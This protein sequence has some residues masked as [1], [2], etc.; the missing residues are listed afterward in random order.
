MLGIRHH[1]RVLEIGSGNRPRS[2]STVLCDR[3]L[4]D[5]V[6]RGVGKTLVLDSRPFVVADGQSLPF[7]DK[8]FD[9]VIVSH[10][11]EHV[12]DPHRF[13]GELMRVALAGYIETPS[14]LGEKIFGWAFH[15]WIVRVDGQRLVLRPRL[16]DSPFGTY[17]HDLYARDLVF[18]EFVDSHYSDFYVQY[19][20]RDRI[21]LTVEEGKD[22]AVRFNRYERLVDTL[23]RW[24]KAAG[25]VLRSLL[26][27]PLRVLRSFRKVV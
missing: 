3:Y 10:V 14:E 20:W 19:E 23:P 11:L 25:T 7:K 5:D 13:V 12:D 27:G 24:R 22:T 26:Q 2:Q 21:L 17:F 1:D 16:E 4:E 9:Y 8:S 15:R 6:H 18:A